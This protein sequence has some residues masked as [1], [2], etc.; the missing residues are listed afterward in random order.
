MF[1]F[2]FILFC[3]V[4]FL[5][6]VLFALFHFV[7][8]RFCFCFC[9]V[10]VVVVVFVFLYFF[11]ITFKS[12]ISKIRNSSH[13]VHCYIQF[14]VWGLTI[15]C[16]KTNISSLLFNSCSNKNMNVRC[17][18]SMTRKCQASHF[19]KYLRYVTWGQTVAGKTGLRSHTRCLFLRTWFCI[20]IHLRKFF[21]RKSNRSLAVLFFY[22]PQIVKTNASRVKTIKVIPSELFLV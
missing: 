12:L 11:I 8:F 14:Y 22:N 7:S 13:L 20:Y 18:I 16:C 21:L 1:G 2:C 10:V 9:F 15:C 3:F 17:L 19:N 5:L 4:L 6:F